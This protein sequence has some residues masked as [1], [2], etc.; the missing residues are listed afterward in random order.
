MR[1]IKPRPCVVCQKVFQ[2]TGHCAKYCS[3][4][5]KAK[6]WTREVLSKR[7][8]DWAVAHGRIKQPGVGTGNGQGSGPTHH[9]WDPSA[10]N[11]DCGAYRKHKKKA[12]ERCAS[13]R[14]LLVHHRNR[15]RGDNSAENSETLCKSC[16][17][18][19]HEVWKNF[20][21]PTR[22]QRHR[23]AKRLAKLNQSLPRV[24]GHNAPRSTR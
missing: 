24:N 11:H 19:E 4:A 22:A 9:S 21:P 13:K 16:H 23:Y 15:D 12:C 17:Q 18:K 2:P 7:A 1:V 5:C 14:F 6:V 20:P 10:P 3:A 8:Y